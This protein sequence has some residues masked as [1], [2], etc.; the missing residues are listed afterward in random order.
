MSTLLVVVASATASALV[1]PPPMVTPGFLLP[2]HPQI[3]ASDVSESEIVDK[4][5]HLRREGKTDAQIMEIMAREEGF[6]LSEYA[7]SSTIP[8]VGD[9]PWGRWSQDTKSMCLEI[10]VNKGTRAT[11]I[12]CEV[13][14]GFLDVRIDGEPV[15]SGRLA[16]GALSDPDWLLEE[17]KNGMKM[18]CIELSKRESKDRVDEGI[19]SSLRVYGEEFVA[20]GLVS[21]NYMPLEVPPPSREAEEAQYGSFD[22]S[23]PDQRGGLDSQA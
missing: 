22:G 9:V 3:M 16:Q 13:Q 2:R 1:L 5:V 10:F 18:L 15:I 4:L 17:Q 7:K 6:D 12:V 21:G 11:S 14:V 19:F 20:P 23:V 8:I